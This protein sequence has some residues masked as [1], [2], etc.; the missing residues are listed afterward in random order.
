MVLCR[1]LRL[2]KGSFFQR[3]SYQSYSRHLC[4]L[5]LLPKTQISPIDDC[6]YNKNKEDCPIILISWGE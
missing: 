2:N 5:N 3:K 6:V 1:V 4:N